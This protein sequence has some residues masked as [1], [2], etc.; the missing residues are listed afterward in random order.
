MR[1]SPQRFTANKDVVRRLQRET[2]EKSLSCARG[3]LRYFGLP[4]SALGDAEEWSELFSEFCAVERG[5]P[6]EE[7]DLQHELELSAF[8][9][10]LFSKIRLF[11]GDIDLIIER[12]RDEFRNK[13]KFP[14]DVVSL[15]YSGGLFYPD[16]AGRMT[17]LR[18]IA[19]LI[20]RQSRGRANF[21]LLISCNLDSVN[22]GEIRRTIDDIRTALARYGEAG[23][24]VIAAY[25]QHP[26]EEARLKLYVPYF[27][28]QESAKNHYNCETEHVIF[29]EGN[30]KTPMMA[31][32][33]GL[34]FDPSTESLKF[35]RERL[36][37]IINSPF[38]EIRDGKLS[39][40]T[41]GLPKLRPP[42]P[43][44]AGE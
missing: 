6:G 40:T 13:V 9:G 5:K 7:W 43:G 14:F 18:A 22:H 24:S 11:R 20:N 1:R 41:L 33:F 19:N 26:R 8:R 35:P 2:I 34:R 31:F 38:V 36:S 28:N 32:R 23:D 17:R 37:Q 3:N 44:G 10:G 25:L 27:V 12:G 21:V 29:Y 15:D 30:K 16:S 39:N 42:Q 4:S